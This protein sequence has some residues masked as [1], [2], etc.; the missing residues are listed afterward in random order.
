MTEAYPLQWPT[1]IP[2][3]DRR[4]VEVS[5]FSPGTRHREAMNVRAELAR[6]GAK[7]VII[8]TNLK[9]RNDG[10]PFSSQ[11]EPD[12]RGVAVYFD[13]LGSQKCFPCD[14]WTKV[15][16]NLRA[17]FKSIEAMRGLER[18]G[19]KSFVE[20]AFTGFT[21]LPAPSA[22]K[23]W[24]EVLEVPRGSTVATIKT[25]YRQKAMDLHNTGA[26]ESQLSELNI[27][28]DK[29]IEETQ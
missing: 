16:D 1:C 6:L 28:R 19:S 27:A 26:D 23:P 13:Y 15:A 4:K 10:L 24:W 20:A 29:A 5:R 18:W 8:S 7:N 25:A 21:A 14:K 9:L 2:R 11:R 3:T 22:S 12:D 17:I